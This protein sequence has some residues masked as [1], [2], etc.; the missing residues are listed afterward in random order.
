MSDTLKRS[1]WVLLFGVALGIGLTILAIRITDVKDVATLLVALVVG[2]IGLATDLWLRLA[3]LDE[4]F[5]GLG[6]KVDAGLAATENESRLAKLIEINARQDP[7]FAIRYSK[8]KNEMGKLAGGTYEIGSLDELY[9]DDVQSIGA[10]NPDEQLLSLCPVSPSDPQGVIEKLS[11]PRYRAS[12]TA[13]QRAFAKGVKVTRIYRFRNQALFERPELKPYVSELAKSEMDL[14]V[15]FEDK[16][17][18]QVD[19]FDFLIFG[20]KK[21][22]IGLVGVGGEIVGGEVYLDPVRIDIY[23]NKYQTIVGVSTAIRDL[24]T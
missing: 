16:I 21:L 5:T 17:P 22:S 8:L 7:N 9:D 24:V 20:N 14:R 6:K 23:K 13:H 2:V 4:K 1:L 12:F 19:N 11:G 15:V 3:D 18:S 10:L